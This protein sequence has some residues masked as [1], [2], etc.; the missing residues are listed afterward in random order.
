MVLG[1]WLTFGLVALDWLE[2]PLGHCKMVVIGR[3][4]DIW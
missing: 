1:T 3:T 2:S 4:V